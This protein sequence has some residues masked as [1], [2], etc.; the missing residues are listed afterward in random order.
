MK[1]YSKILIVVLLAY[2]LDNLSAAILKPPKPISL[3]EKNS[4]V[5]SK[6]ILVQNQ[7]IKSHH[8]VLGNFKVNPVIPF[9]IPPGPPSPKLPPA[10]SPAPPE[11][12]TVPPVL[13]APPTPPTPLSPP[14]PPAPTFLQNIKKENVNHQGFD[15]LEEGDDYDEEE[16][17]EEIE[18]EDIKE[19]LENSKT[20]TSTPIQNSPTF[21]LTVPEIVK[22]ENVNH[23]SFDKFVEGDDYDEEEVEEVEDGD[24]EEPLE[25]SKTVTNAPILSSPT[26]KLTV[27]EIVKQ[28]NDNRGF[29]KLEEGDYY[30]EGDDYEE[31]YDEAVVEEKDGHNS[32]E[33]LEEPNHS[34]TLIPTKNITINGVQ[35]NPPLIINNTITTIPQLSEDEL[36][37]NNYYDSEYFI[38]TNE[39]NQEY[40]NYN[41]WESES[42]NIKNKPTDIYETLDRTNENT[43]DQSINNNEFESK[44]YNNTQIYTDKQEENIGNQFNNQYVSENNE[45]IVNGYRALKKILYMLHDYASLTF[46]WIINKINYRMEQL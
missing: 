44:P 38:N 32:K 39:D 3:N 20:V 23:Q 10:V 34:T 26:S 9:N 2:F 22:Q 42:S 36:T 31:D 4:P 21:K 11:L 8:P 18:D 5:Q 1:M 19:P 17:E 14:T 33:Y 27:P 29:D 35:V 25:N 40:Q 37:E 41:E 24:I 16:V 7:P 12:T 45:K 6:N 13:S 30:E 46:D 15:K 28:K 43:Q